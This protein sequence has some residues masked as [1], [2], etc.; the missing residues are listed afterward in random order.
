[1]SNRDHHSPPRVALDPAELR[2]AI[3][4]ADLRVL[5]MCL[6]HFTGDER[7]LE[8]PYQPRRDVRLIADEAAGLPEEICREIR[9]AVLEQLASG[10]SKPV[11]DNPDEALLQRMMNV[12]LGENVPSEYA[13][14]MRE[15][16]GFESGDPAWASPPAPEA[17]AQTR[18]L[19][20]G[21]GVCGLALAIQLEK[22]GVEYCVVEKNPE[23][24]GTWYENRYPGC[25]VDT[26]NHAYSYSFA[27]NSWPQYFSPRSDIQAYLERCAEQFGVRRRI[28]FDTELVGAS[29]DEGSRHW[30]ATLRSTAAQKNSEERVEA[31]VLI[32]AIGQL[33]L[34]AI[35]EIDGSESFAGP[36]FHSARWPESL[37]LVG[38]RVAVLGTGASSMQLVPTIAD[39]VAE[40]TVYQRSP[41][42]VRPVGDYHRRVS[43][44][45]QWL[46]DHVPFYGTW[47]RFTLFWRFGDSLLPFLQKDPEWPHPERSLNS[48]NDR[49]RVELEEFIRSELADSPKLISQCT[50]SYPPY[51]KRILIDNG[52]FRTLLK[53]N[54][55]LVSESVVRIEEDAIVTAD[56]ERR[57]ADVIVM[58][59][60][61]QITDMAARLGIRGRNGLDLAEA[62][63]DENPTAFLG[64]SVPGFPNFFCMYG[65]NTNLGHG[66]SL[67]FHGECQARYIAGCIVE[68]IESDIAAIDCKREA[69]DDYV[70]RVD[71]AH[72]KMI[73]THPGM[74]T[75]YRNRHGRVVST[76]PWRLVDYWAMT[77]DPDFGDYRVEFRERARRPSAS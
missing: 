76:S 2:T 44:G 65:P 10:V 45:T 52:W 56:G 34:P 33:N 35:P 43:P 72:E 62:W 17:L 26:P 59:T 69:H 25:G 48:G 53:P 51:G 37:D 20:V 74:S 15:D 64:I 70:R 32:S 54:V 66:G 49:H 18:V 9:E 71:E 8:P 24:G 57:P 55:N 13:P 75:W 1:V 77:H 50:P 41:Q 16:M 11:I 61:F 27:P 12:C 23:V 7:W 5:L 36:L 22:L 14:M 68:M 30:V 42:W 38:K 19:I 47:F 29:W 40:L 3:E 58:A 31:A 67:M 39:E 60:G 6:F 21:A 73:W 28:R 63:A 4:D 46:L